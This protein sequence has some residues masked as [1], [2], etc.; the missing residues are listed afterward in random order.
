MLLLV[1]VEFQI[2]YYQLHFLG[3]S[4][5]RLQW[6]PVCLW[7][8]FSCCCDLMTLSF[9]HLFVQQT[10]KISRDAFDYHVY[11]RYYVSWC[12]SYALLF[13]RHEFYHVFYRLF[14]LRFSFPFWHLL[15]NLPPWMLVF[16]QSVI[17]Q[18]GKR[19]ISFL[20]LSIAMKLFKKPPTSQ[21]KTIS[22]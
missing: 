11:L 20:F 12:R 5:S 21:L 19:E 3:L 2:C 18:P 13:C 1:Q 6:L 8:Q 16:L 4:I 15:M 17:G 14:S 9:F 22:R 7:N 10:L